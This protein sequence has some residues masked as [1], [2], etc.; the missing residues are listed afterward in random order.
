MIFIIRENS[1]DYHTKILWIS[2]SLQTNFSWLYWWC[3]VQSGMMDG[4]LQLDPSLGIPPKRLV[5]LILLPV[6]KRYPVLLPVYNQ[7][8]WHNIP[9]VK[10]SCLSP[11]FLTYHFSQ[12]VFTYVC[13][14]NK[15]ESSQMIHQT[16]VNMLLW[17]FLRNSDLKW[18]IT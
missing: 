9:V 8:F 10:T 12:F 2:V 16:D 3:N 18:P 1:S 14:W 15:W 11:A 4:M 7:H 5:W 17:N 6:V 13:C